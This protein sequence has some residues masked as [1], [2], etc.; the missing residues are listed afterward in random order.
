MDLKL[1]S[2]RFGELPLSNVMPDQYAH[3]AIPGT[4]LRSAS[5]AKNSLVL[6][7]R[8]SGPFSI[9]HSLLSGSQPDHLNASYLQGV[10]VLHLSLQG[11]IRYQVQGLSP[12]VLHERSYTIYY[13]PVWLAKIHITDNTSRSILLC[14]APDVFHKHSFRFERAK[15]V[16]WRMRENEPTKLSKHR[17]IADYNLLMMLG[18][19]L[20]GGGDIDW[21][22]EAADYAIEMTLLKNSTPK[23]KLSDDEI[24]RVYQ[25][26]EIITSDLKV[27]HTTEEL[28]KAT[29]LNHYQLRTWFSLVYGMS[30]SDYRIET[31]IRR[32][33]EL[34]NK[35][36]KVVV[37]ASQVGYSES[38]LRRTFSDYFGC[39][40]QEYTRGLRKKE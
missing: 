5:W 35:G 12:I 15:E 24:G 18:N 8:Q 6:Q 16:L 13:A 33:V 26:R 39:T 7:C 19:A 30:I 4:Q 9:Y 29:D 20:E 27:T 3:L 25:I 22:A 36:E 14:M 31:K 32:A 38:Q 1:S 34:L 11:T 10:V 23:N 17:L 2:S 28:S 40:I 21:Q 37:I